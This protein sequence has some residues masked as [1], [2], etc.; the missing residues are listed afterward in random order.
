MNDADRLSAEFCKN[1]ELLNWHDSQLLGFSVTE[2]SRSHR[3]SLDIRW[4]QRSNIEEKVGKVI[5]NE[6]TY[7]ILD[8]DLDGKM[9]CSDSIACGI[10][11]I[12]S[13]LK[14]QLQSEKFKFEPGR[15]NDFYHFTIELIPP[16]G[17]MHIFA[18]SFEVE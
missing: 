2:L 5:F 16:G 15:L 1:F 17:E 8:L 9:V 11:Q 12:N 3:V 4:V 18:K 7:M 13:A 10:C 14:G 6:C